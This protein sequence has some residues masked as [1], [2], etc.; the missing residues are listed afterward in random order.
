VKPFE[1]SWSTGWVVMVGVT[2]SLE[3]ELPLP[4]AL[5]AMHI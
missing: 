3:V 4:A 1:T 2:R 5:L